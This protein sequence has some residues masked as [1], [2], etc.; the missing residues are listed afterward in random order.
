[1][2][3]PL[4]NPA[5]QKFIDDHLGADLSKMAFKYKEVEG[6]SIQLILQQIQG[7][8]KAKDKIPSWY[9]TPGII[10]PPTLNLEQSSSEATALY[11]A[12]LIRGKTLI[13]LTGGFGI[14]TASFSSH[15]ENV[16][17]VERNEALT[18]IVR[19]NLEAF[20]ITNVEVNTGDAESFL[21]KVTEADVIFIDPARRDSNNNRVFK[22]ED[23]EPDVIRLLPQLFKKTEHIVIKTSP[24]LEIK[25]TIRAL[26]SVSEVHVVALENDCKEVLYLLKKDYSSSPE[27]YA[28]NLSDNSCEKFHFNYE[29]ENNK[30]I[31]SPPLRY[32]YEP[33]SSILKASAYNSVAQVYKLSKLHPN[34]HLYTSDVLLQ[35]FPGRKFEIIATSKYDRKQ[36][37]AV[38][39]SEKANVTAR[40]F[41][42]SVTQIRKKLQ[43]KDGGEVYLFATTD[44]DNRL[45]LVV[46]KKA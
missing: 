46:T 10:F 41:S 1:V 8:I 2:N 3:S 14:D 31:L 7:K 16:I 28:V 39:T 11:K 18:E 9:S 38:L 34:S 12:R 20:Q 23:C 24:L 29:D 13:D 30:A 25:S 19:H 32:L 33:N 40:N 27:I 6:V 43:L 26:K 5:I 22:L 4:V 37:M 35:D 42:D 17:Y 15:F 44:L 21:S 45:I 36:L